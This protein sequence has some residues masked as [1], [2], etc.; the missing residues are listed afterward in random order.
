M[1]KN[2]GGIEQRIGWENSGFEF[3]SGSDL[4]RTVLEAFGDAL[5]AKIHSPEFK[6]LIVEAASKGGADQTNPG[7]PA[8]FRL[9]QEYRRLRTAQN[10]APGT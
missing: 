8:V 4:L 7:D 2:L 6:A 10:V 1:W 3:V 9:L 5:P